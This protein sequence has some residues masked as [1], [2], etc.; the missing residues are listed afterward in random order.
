VYN[1]IHSE[2]LYE[3]I[4]QQIQA[5]ILSGDLEAGH[6]LPTERELAEQFGV[7][8]TAV[9]EAMRVLA[10]SGLIEVRP[11][12]GTFVI[13]GAPKAIKHSLGLAV[14]IGQAAGYSDLIEIR[15]MLEVEIAGLAAQRA[16]EEHI[17]AMQDTVAAMDSA[18][19]AAD[20]FC[21]ADLDFHLALAQGTQNAL[22]PMLIDSVVDLLRW[23][24]M[25]I[26]ASGG[27][28]RGQNGHKR[29]LDA[30]VHHDPEAAREAMRAHLKQARQDSEGDASPMG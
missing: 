6:Q 19:D 16:T 23:Q 22:I 20:A 3:R 24:R 29:I 25:R 14:K 4:V 9:R 1:L 26:Y 5:R 21:E 18:M 2:R 28:T 15:E 13:D 27:A 17:A 11:G 7:S 12:R 8:R 30:V 10:Q